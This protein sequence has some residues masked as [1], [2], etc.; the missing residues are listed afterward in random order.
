MLKGYL[1]LR[2][3]PRDGNLLKIKPGFLDQIEVRRV[4]R[5]EKLHN[6]KDRVNLCVISV[7]IGCSVILLYHSIWMSLLILLSKEE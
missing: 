3:A 5:L 1:V 6:L 4:A 2:W 7:D